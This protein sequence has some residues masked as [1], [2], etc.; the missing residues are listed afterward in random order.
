[1]NKKQNIYYIGV[2]I[3]QYKAKTYLKYNN[4]VTLA[5]LN[6]KNEIIHK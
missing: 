1:M 6:S 2:L 3:T 4:C 5:H